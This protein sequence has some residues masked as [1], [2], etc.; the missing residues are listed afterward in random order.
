MLWLGVPPILAPQADCIH[1]T[2]LMI[3]YWWVTMLITMII[4]RTWIWDD[5]HKERLGAWVILTAPIIG[6]LMPFILLGI[7][8]WLIVTEIIKPLLITAFGIQSPVWYIKWLWFKTLRSYY[9]F[10]GKV[11]YPSNHPSAHDKHL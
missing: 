11:K 4:G 9:M 3:I 7:L 2:S 6:S 10:R 5:L 8:I 1:V